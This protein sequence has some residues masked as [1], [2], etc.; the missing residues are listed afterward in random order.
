MCLAAVVLSHGN[1]LLEAYG[2]HG[3]EALQCMVERRKGGESGICAVQAL[4][5]AD[6]WSAAESGRW[7]IELCQ[8]A[9]AVVGLAGATAGGDVYAANE[10]AADAAAGVR[11]S[12]SEA[13]A[14]VAA[15]VGSDAVLFL[16]TYSDGF[17]AAL[18]HCQGEGN[19]IG[20]WAY[21]A[22]V[23][24]EVKATCFNGSSGP[25]YAAFSYMGLNVEKMFESKVAT[26]P[27]ERT[28]L[29]T[30]ALDAAMSSHAE[31]GSRP[32]PTP[33]LATLAVSRP[34]RTAPAS[35]QYP[36]QPCR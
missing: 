13:A 7:S 34:Q 14:A 26:W 28:L 11:G 31:G 27:V 35:L 1:G 6:I 9:L 19:V 18:L 21:A 36:G 20:G 3:L 2:Y 25:N 10:D 23:G 8:A 4:S 5:G 16:L 29:V 32:M 22:S 12:T 33:H 30:G 17:T 24:G 15:V